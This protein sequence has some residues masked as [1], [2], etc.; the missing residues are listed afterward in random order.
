VLRE[1]WLSNLAPTVTLFV[2]F[3]S[4]PAERRAESFTGA[5]PLTMKPEPG[6]SSWNAALALGSLTQS[7]AY[8]TRA[9]SVHGML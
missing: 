5:A 4:E 7:C 9:R 8:A 6:P 1:S 2:T 3:S